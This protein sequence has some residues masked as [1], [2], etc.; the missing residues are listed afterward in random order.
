MGRRGVPANHPCLFEIPEPIS[1]AGQMDYRRSVSE[2]FTQILKDARDDRYTIAAAMSRL[3][4]RDV[5]K[6]MLDAYCAPSREEFNLPFYLVPAAEV[7]ATSHILTNWLAGVR[8]SE[9]LVGKDALLAELGRLQR[10]RDEASKKMASLKK[11]IDIQ[12]ELI[13]VGANR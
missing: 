7:A 11:L 2:L 3:A 8:G 13:D 4:G 9:L 12:G 5:T 6:Y 10:T 1:S